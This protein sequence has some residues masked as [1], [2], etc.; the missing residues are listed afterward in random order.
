MEMNMRLNYLLTHHCVERLRERFPHIADKY[1]ELR[2][3]KR[4]DNFSNVKKVMNIIL[5]ESEENKSFLNNSVEMIKIYEKY[6]Y[7]NEYKI[8]ELRNEEI[9]FIFSKE[10]SSN[11]FK[12]VTVMP[13]HFRPISK[14]V[15]YNKIE[16]KHSKFNKML[17]SWY[18]NHHNDVPDLLSYRNNNLSLEI[19]YKLIEL[20]NENKTQKTLKI[21]KTQ[22]QHKVVWQN[23]QYE[24]I[25]SKNANNIENIEVL[26]QKPISEINK[27][28]KP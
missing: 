26:S 9:L 20:V 14:V 28:L 10:R 4:G 27:K 22:A 21:S 6:G 24:F 13:T 15:K 1:V 3:W 7:D 16:T 23:T 17:N 19:K 2:E 11:S 25:Y 5:N 12:L 8:Y 18:E